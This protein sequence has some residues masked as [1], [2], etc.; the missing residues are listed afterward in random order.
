MSSDLSADVKAINKIPVVSRLLDVIYRTTG[1]GFAAIARVTDEKW[2]TC[3]S[4]DEVNFGLKPGDELKLETTICHEVRQNRKA[5]IIEDVGKD[6]IYCNHHTPKIY[7]IKSYISVPIYRRNGDFF[8]TLCAIDAQP[9]PINTPEIVGMFELFAELIG[10]HLDAV[11]EVE[12]AGQ[13]LERQ[14]EIASLR[15]EFIGILGHDL[16]NPIASTRMSAEILMKIAQDDMSR[17][18]A[19]MIKATSYRMD[20]LIGNML[21]FARGRLGEGIILEKQLQNGDLIKLLEQE[22]QELQ[23][24]SPER[25]IKVDFHLDREVNCDRERIAQLLS[26]LLNNADSHGN[27]DHPI[28]VEAGT[29]GEQF[30]L[31]V[32]NSGEVIPDEALKHLFEPFYRE[33]NVPSKNGLGLGLYISSEIAKAHDGTLSVSSTED[34]TRFI[35][36]MPLQ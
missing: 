11:E 4:R 16:R 23:V 12:A 9:R 35:L 5:V 8:G 15:E 19:A 24:N 18:H 2:I 22:I 25:E 3:S 7:G 31:S 29:A 1:M 26:N 32:T 6:K 33:K 27:K 20:K 21:D 14:Q 30:F 34:Q 17:R 36:E 28:F 10:F 13:K